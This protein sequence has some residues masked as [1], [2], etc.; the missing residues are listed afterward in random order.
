MNR[1]RGLVYQIHE[2]VEARRDYNLCAA[3][4]LTSVG[5]FV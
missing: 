3:V 2:L 1:Y 4:E 5:R